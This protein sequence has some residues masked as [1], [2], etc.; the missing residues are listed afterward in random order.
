M[1]REENKGKGGEKGMSA[2]GDTKQRPMGAKVPTCTEGPSV[3]F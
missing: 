1:G 2:G 3:E